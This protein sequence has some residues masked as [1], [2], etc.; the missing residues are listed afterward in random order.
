MKISILSKYRK[1]TDLIIN[2]N[3]LLD[4]YFYGIDISSTDGTRLSSGVI[5]TYIRA[6]QSEIE[7]YLAIKLKKSLET[8]TTDYYRDDFTIGYPVIETSFQVNEPYTCMG[9]LNSIEQ[10][11]YPKQWLSANKSEGKGW[12]REISIVPNGSAVSGNTDVILTG[13][14]NQYSFQS[15][16]QVPNY[17][18]VQYT[19]GFDYDKVPYDLLNV[20]G[21]ISAISVLAIAGDILLGAG[22]AS[23]SL[24]IDGLSQQIA[25]TNSATSSAFNARILQYQKEVKETLNKLKAYYKGFNFVSL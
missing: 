12:G 17:F 19:T 5:E 9:L 23:Q 11:N 3:E 1:N 25:T 6:A 13:V 16:R 10:I 21:K 4:L 22:I 7:K 2:P 15:Q 18:T 8:E 14:M 20:I 24:S